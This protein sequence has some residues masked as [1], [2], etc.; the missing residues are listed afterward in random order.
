[1]SIRTAS[2]PRS[3]AAG[4]RPP[5]PRLPRRLRVE[6]LEGRDVPSAY[7]QTNLASDVPGQALVYD[8]ELVDGW[9]LALSGTPTA[10]FWVSSRA[11]GV[12][13]VYTGDRPGVPFAKS[14]LTV[15]IPGDGPTGQVFSGSATDFMVSSGATAGPSRFI[16][17]SNTGH[18]TGWN[19]NVPL[20]APSRTAH[21]TATTPGANYTG[22]AIGNNGTGNFLYAADFNNGRIDVFNSTWQRADL[23]GSFTDPNMRDDYAPFNVQALAGKLYVTYAQQHDDGVP[24]GGNGFVSVFDMNG[25]FQKRLVSEGGLQAPWGMTLAPA[26]FGQFSN[27]LLVG[28]FEGGQI[29]A[30][31]RTTGK[32]L[33][34]LREPD[35]DRVR[36]DGLWG[37]SFGN[38][39]TGDPKALYFTAGPDNQ[40]HGLLGRL[41]LVPDGSRIAGALVVESGGKTAAQPV[42]LSGLTGL[43]AADATAPLPDRSATADD[44]RPAAPAPADQPAAELTA[45]DEPER[46]DLGAGKPAGADGDP[47]AVD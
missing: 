35:G 31:D 37:L 2:R 6:P 17:V 27:A 40:R 10:T 22:L 14:T 45:A 21:M 38:A 39:F 47:L 4:R 20:P 12:S 16:T 34:E 1:M 43:F 32:F 33:G 19:P 7:V 28:N 8:P 29:R 41:N 36:I 11:A 26:D 18:L 30:Y 44:G 5:H 23:G 25:N 3:P 13:T 46:P 9:G 15:T 24:H 42:L